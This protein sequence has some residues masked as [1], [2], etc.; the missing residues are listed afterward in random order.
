[1]KLKGACKYSLI[2]YSDLLIYDVNRIILFL[3]CKQNWYKILFMSY[4]NSR[5]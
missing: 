2:V 5:V 1:M 4:A 3:I